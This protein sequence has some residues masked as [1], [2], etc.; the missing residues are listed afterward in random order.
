MRPRPLGP[1]AVLRLHAI[2][3]T[4]TQAYT[5]PDLIFS[6]EIAPMDIFL[7]MQC[8]AGLPTCIDLPSELEELSTSDGFNLPS[9]TTLGLSV[10][11][12]S[13]ESRKNTSFIMNRFLEETLERLQLLACVTEFPHKDGP[14]QPIEQF[15]GPSSQGSVDPR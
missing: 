2:C 6:I 5:T 11:M 10:D 14:S 4:Q 7:V 13:D 9:S 15:P 12:V 8:G 1:T 3:V